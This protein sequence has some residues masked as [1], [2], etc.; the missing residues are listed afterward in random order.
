MSNQFVIENSLLA[1]IISYEHAKYQKIV[2]YMKYNF[3]NQPL[4][5][6]SRARHITLLFSYGKIDILATFRRFSSKFFCLR[7]SSTV[8][9]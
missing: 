8:L 9:P 6:T 5:K 7:F 1:L 4:G 2:G 3:S